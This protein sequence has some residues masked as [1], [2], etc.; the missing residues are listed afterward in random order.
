M[1]EPVI[2]FTP[3]QFM[4][5]AALRTIVRIIGKQD[6]SDAMDEALGPI[7]PDFY[8]TKIPDA[9]AKEALVNWGKLLTER[10]TNVHH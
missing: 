3:A 2:K 5:I 8:E 7:L 4:E 9:A 6:L 1:T 10:V